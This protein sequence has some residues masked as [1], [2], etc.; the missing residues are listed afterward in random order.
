MTDLDSHTARRARRGRQW[1]LL[2]LLVL[3]VP[4]AW[5]EGRVL[6]VWAEDV[7]APPD[8]ALLEELG[9]AS[10]LELTWLREV[11]AGISLLAWRSLEP[12]S[13][14]E[15]LARLALDPRVEAVQPDARRRL[16]FV[17]NDPLYEHQWYLF[18]SAGIRAPA[19]W[20]LQR[21][22]SSVVV[23]VLD[24]GIL[25]HEDLAPAR[26]LPGYDFYSD[27]AHD[28]DGEPGR[29]ADPRDPG[30]AVVADECGIGTPA[31]NSSWHGLAVSGLIM[32]SA[33]NTRGIAGIDHGARLLPVRVFGK[34]GAWVSDLFDAMRWAAGLAVSG[35]P[36]NP[37]P[38]GV[39]NLSLAYDEPCGV[40]EQRIIDEVIA[41]GAVV[42]A[43]A[44]NEAGD[45]ANSSPASCNG[46]ITV[47]ASDRAGKP[48]SFTN[49]GAAVDITAPGVSLVTSYNLGTTYP[50]TDTYDWLSGTSFST[51]QV[52]AVLALMRADRPTATV[53]QLREALRAGA[54]AFPDSS[55]D[56]SL[57]GAGL[58]DAQGAILALREQPAPTSGGGGG[59]VQGS[60]GR[61]EALWWLGL[62]WVLYRLG[63]RNDPAGGRV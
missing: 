17:P 14:A 51:A 54:R 33:D 53:N 18:E 50:G 12:L 25:P 63:R 35:A 16:Q 57:C 29:D 55:C 42:V 40:A 21:G 45:V 44:G 19:A 52:S 24:T 23:A 5:A 10:G 28:N 13:A 3:S 41:R 15:V 47:A 58:L 27:L 26:M 38:A 48:A 34:C 36:S 46:V 61:P 11:S 39:I 60:E 4:L 2:C 9:A 20:D 1:L 43:A 22:S 49:L 32:A 7:A 62:L 37:T 6:V 59:C 30:D 56:T 31:V 8:T